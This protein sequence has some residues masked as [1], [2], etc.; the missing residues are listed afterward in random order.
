IMSYFRRIKLTFEALRSCTSRI[1][2]TKAPP[3]PSA[4]RIHQNWTRNPAKFSGFSSYAKFSPHLVLQYPVKSLLA[5]RTGMLIDRYHGSPGGLG[6]CLGNCGLHEIEADYIGL[7]LMAAAG[8]D[9]RIAPQVWEELGKNNE[10]GLY[11]ELLST[12]PSGRKRAQLLSHALVMEKA[13][14]IWGVLLDTSQPKKIT[15]TIHQY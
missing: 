10:T 7:M 5:S 3:Q 1:I 14:A 2:T 13:L 6:T 15:G 11:D 12:H 8:Y 4:S 9:P